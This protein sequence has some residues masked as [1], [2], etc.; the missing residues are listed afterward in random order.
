MQVSGSHFSSTTAVYIGGVQVEAYAPSDSVID[1]WTPSASAAGTLDITVAN[2][3]G[4]SSTSSADQFTYMAPPAI[5]SISPGGGPTNGGHAGADQRQR[6]HWGRRSVDLRRR[7]TATYSVLSATQ[8]AATSPA[9]S[10]P[11]DVDR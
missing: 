8:I 3:F 7:P 2:A 1:L 6:L 5:T 9:F 10:W 11:Y 4:T